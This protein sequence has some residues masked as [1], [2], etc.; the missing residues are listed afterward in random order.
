MTHRNRPEET[1][2]TT[3]A[4]RKSRRPASTSRRTQGT[5]AQTAA[6]TSTSASS[7]PADAV[8]TGACPPLQ[9]SCQHG[10]LTI[11]PLRNSQECTY[12]HRLPPRAHVLPDASLDVFGREKH[13]QYR[14]DMGGVGSFSRQNRTLYIGRIKETRD[15]PEIV[16]EHFSEFGEIERSE[17]S[18]QTSCSCSQKSCWSIPSD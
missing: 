18:F 2:T 12:L 16:E 17:S 5:P 11:A 9:R 1:S 13:S 3:W 15:T 7:S 4:S 10:A 14:D 8:P 6:A